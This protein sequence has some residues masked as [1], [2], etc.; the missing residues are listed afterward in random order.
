[1]ST[2]VCPVYIYMRHDGYCSWYALR[3]YNSG[4]NC[5]NPASLD[6]SCG[7]TPGCPQNPQCPVQLSVRDVRGEERAKDKD[8]HSHA[9]HEAHG[10]YGKKP[11]P[12]KEHEPTPGAVI[13]D[14]ELG[15]EVRYV[16]FNDP[17][18]GGGT[19]DACVCWVRVTPKWF[20]D[21]EIKEGS[22]P[23]PASPAKVA[24]VKSQPG[25]ERGIGCQVD[26]PAGA[27]IHRSED[28]GEVA[29]VPGS[30]QDGCLTIVVHIKG[31]RWYPYYITLVGKP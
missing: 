24:H 5:V 27:V 21:A 7:L 3:C 26:L 4:P 31:N 22:P 8:H 6:G 13:L 28:D 18:G 10:M 29:I 15:E 23:K 12:G 2:G 11:A 30:V 9:D 16:R 19:I 17:K 14:P 1:M 20:S 25:F